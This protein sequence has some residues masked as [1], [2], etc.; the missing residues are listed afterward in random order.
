[1]LTGIRLR[2]IT[3]YLLVI[4]VIVFSMGLF[5]IF[6]LNYFYM[7][8]IRENLYNQA[9]LVAV[10]AEDMLES[11]AASAEID[12]LFKTLGS[13]LGVRLTLVDGDGSVLADS[14][15]DPGLMENHKDRPEIMQAIA[16]EKGV[17]SRYSVTL[18][19]NMY[20]LAIPLRPLLPDDGLQTDPAAVVRLALPLSA[21]N[22]AVS[23]LVIFILA[24]LLL[25]SLLALLTAI[26]LSRRITGPI[27]VISS[28]A[29]DI[30]GGNY[31]PP[32]EI[33]GKDELAD[34]AV[35]IR[36]MGEALNKKINQVLA[37]KNKLETIVSSMSSGIILTDSALTIE[38]INPAAEK[39]F[40]LNRN[41]AIGMPFSKAV[42]YYA[43]YENLK[44][45]ILDGE[46]RMM[47]VNLYYPRAV[48]LDTYILPLCGAESTVIGVLLLFHE[49][50]ELRSIEKMR[51]DFVANISHELRTPLTTVRGYTETILHEDLSREQLLVFLEVIDRETK[52]LSSLLDDLLDLAQIENEKGLVKKVILNLSDLISEAVQRVEDQRQQKGTAIEV[53]MPN[54]EVAVSGNPEWLRQALVNVLENSIK[55]GKPNGKIRVEL[56]LEKGKAMVNI[57]DNGPGIPEEDLPYVFER[58]YRVDKARSRKSGGTGL[59]LSIVKHIMEAHDAE[60][61]LHSEAGK[62]AIFKFTLPLSSSP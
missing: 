58:F 5:F 7:Q 38:I 36:A 35:N 45:I 15:Q 59:G 37:E 21:I 24:A 50:T 43:L 40:D 48:L 57:I 3:Y 26:L 54:E 29:R 14:D 27:G 42:R 34:L 41:E 11:N 10:L 32:L 8:T 60:Y 9:R 56:A 30:A 39:L 1:M 18:D 13:E 33:T 6:F 20:Y 19:E 2:L 31:N 12:A 28:A 55:H 47:E 22:R 52:R 62:G 17:A 44:S 53:I 4:A 61:S 25:A 51:S 46:A 23:N 49:T 16:E